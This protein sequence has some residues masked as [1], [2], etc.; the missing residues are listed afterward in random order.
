MKDL[1]VNI[2]IDPSLKPAENHG[3]RQPMLWEIDPERIIISILHNTMGLANDIV[4]RLTDTLVVHV[5]SLSPCERDLRKFEETEAGEIKELDRKEEALKVDIENARRRIDE[6]NED[7]KRD[8]HHHFTPEEKKAKRE[9]RERIKSKKNDD[10][11]ALS[12]TKKEL[13][14][15]VSRH[16]FIKKALHA[17]VQQ[18]RKNCDSAESIFY[19]VLKKFS[20]HRAQYHGGALTG[21]H[22][23]IL[24]SK[25]EAIFYALVEK[26]QEFYGEIPD[27]NR[28]PSEWTMVKVQRTLNHYKDMLMTLDA[29]V[30]GMRNI[31]PTEDECANLKKAIEMLEHKWDFEDEE[32]AITKLSK[33]PKAHA[34]FA[35]AFEQFVKF[36]GFGDKDEEFIEKRHQIGLKLDY[37]S[38]RMKQGFEQK[39]RQT[40]K[41]RSYLHN[42]KVQKCIEDVKKWSST[43]SRFKKR[44]IAQKIEIKM[45]KA[46]KRKAFIDS[47]NNRVHQRRRNNNE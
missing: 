30:S 22:C 2:A 4:K 34:I 38:K 17:L 20:I 32:L 16:K 42:W 15:K 36:G 37:M 8:N 28:H 46:A 26:F 3:V 6:I 10:I 47:E 11:K 40:M 23:R 14:D 18:R 29:V 7:L 41:Y 9:E 5:D 44:T 12:N 25:A 45:E 43:Q 13:D 35:H 27:E 33:T 24:C 21:G 1:A 31:H 19:E 39:Q